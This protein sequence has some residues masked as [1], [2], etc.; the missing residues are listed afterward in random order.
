MLCSYPTLQEVIPELAV[1][2]GITNCHW[3]SVS[4]QICSPRSQMTIFQKSLWKSILRIHLANLDSKLL[5]SD[6]TLSS[7]DIL[8][9]SMNGQFE[10]AQAVNSYTILCYL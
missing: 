10:F 7:F 2:P 8:F 4:H 9:E 5:T 1:W 3:T 6:V